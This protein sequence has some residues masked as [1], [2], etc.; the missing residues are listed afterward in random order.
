MDKVIFKGRICS[1]CGRK[2][3]QQ[4]TTLF[5]CKCGKSFLKEGRQWISFNRESGMVFALDKNKKA[6]IRNGL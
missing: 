4:F 6:Y 5:H 2:T 1:F 3:K